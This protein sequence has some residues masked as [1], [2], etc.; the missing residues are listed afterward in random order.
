MND[1]S[2]AGHSQQEVEQAIHALSDA[3]WLRLE[4]AARYRVSGLPQINPQEILGEAVVRLMNEARNWPQGVAFAAFFR[5][6][7]RSVASEYRKD[8]LAPVEIRE[9]DLAPGDEED[10]P[11]VA[12]LTPGRAID[13]QKRLQISEI[14]KE[15]QAHFGADDDVEAVLLGLEAGYTGKEIQAEFGLSDKA[16]GA[17]RKRWERWLAKYYPN[18]IPL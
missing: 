17:A 10:A 2:Q 11:S 7:L 9:A 15:I 3:D 8:L 6:V 5:G 1:S 16:F 12:E 13:P 4:R 18:G 14:M